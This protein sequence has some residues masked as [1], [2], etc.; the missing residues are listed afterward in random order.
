MLNKVNDKSSGNSGNIYTKLSGSEIITEA[1][2]VTA[3]Y[4]YM[5]I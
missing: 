1:L 5:E 3:V 2:P 4:N